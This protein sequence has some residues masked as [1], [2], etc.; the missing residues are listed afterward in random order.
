MSADGYIRRVG[1]SVALALSAHHLAAI[2]DSRTLQ[3]SPESGRHADYD[4]HT[5]RQGWNVHLAV[6]TLGHLLAVGRIRQ[7]S[8]IGL[9]GDLLKDGRQAV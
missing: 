9:I 7:L 1:T 4:R 5:R 8:H 3:S 6:N 2:L